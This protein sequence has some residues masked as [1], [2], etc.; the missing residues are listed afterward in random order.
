[1]LNTAAQIAEIFCRASDSEREQLFPPSHHWFL[2]SAVT[3]RK[4]FGVPVVQRLRFFQFCKRSA[5]LASK[6]VFA[7]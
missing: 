6:E 2:I 7:R 5:E 4:E 3:A 1:M